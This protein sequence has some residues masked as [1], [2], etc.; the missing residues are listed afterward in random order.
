MLILSCVIKNVFIIVPLLDFS[1]FFRFYYLFH[2]RSFLQN[3][4]LSRAS[5]D[6]ENT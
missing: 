2:S 5:A 1:D 6:V 4:Y 3:V